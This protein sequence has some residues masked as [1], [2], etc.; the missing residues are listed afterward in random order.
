MLGAPEQGKAAAEVAV[1]LNVDSG[2]S[3]L[4]T[5]MKKDIIYPVS[6]RLRSV[7]GVER[8]HSTW[9]IGGSQVR[10]V[11]SGASKRSK[12][13]KPPKKQPLS[14]WE[15]FSK[16]SMPC[17]EAGTRLASKN[18]LCQIDF[19]KIYLTNTKSQM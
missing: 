16:R 5:K 7:A 4:A 18:R 9:P 15:T 6:S 11:I 10:R 2:Q 17:P 19:S 12:F 8:S 13:F 3:I 14:F 1:L